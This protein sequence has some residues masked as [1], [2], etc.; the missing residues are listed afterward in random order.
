[1][2]DI[3]S[4]INNVKC[5]YYY[6][7]QLPISTVYLET[8]LKLRL[9]HNLSNLIYT[10]NAIIPAILMFDEEPKLRKRVFPAQGHNCG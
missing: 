8:T 1:M 6:S 9:L 4:H 10:T 3:R 2:S 7:T 5:L